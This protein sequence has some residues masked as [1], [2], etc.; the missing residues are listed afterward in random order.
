LLK[1]TSAELSPEQMQALSDHYVSKNGYLNFPSCAP[2]DDLKAAL[3]NGE[4]D[5]RF[6]YNVTLGTVDLLD[7]SDLHSA[8]EFLRRW[9]EVTVDG[10]KIDKPTMMD[11]WKP[12]FKGTHKKL[13]SRVKVTKTDHIMASVFD[14]FFGLASATTGL[15]ALGAANLLPVIEP[16]ATVDTAV[17]M[18][19]DARKVVVN[20]LVEAYRDALSPLAFYT[21]ASGLLPDA[22]GDVPAF[23]SEQMLLRHPDAKI[24][25]ALSEALFYLLPGGLV[26]T[27]S[28]EQAYYST[29]RGEKKAKEIEDAAVFASG[30]QASA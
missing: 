29:E 19:T 26:L 14:A 1:E 23:T 11:W 2:Y 18:L 10:V 17:E 12:G 8:T 13:S 25:K 15:T 9:Y 16:R 22:F 5:V 20:L 30:P 21:G 3:S 6:S 27:V 24:G 4:I 7:P 28:V